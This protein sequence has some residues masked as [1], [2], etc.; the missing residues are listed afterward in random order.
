MNF[1]IKKALRKLLDKLEI[2]VATT[3]I[4]VSHEAT[5]SIYSYTYL[6]SSTY[7]YSADF[8]VVQEQ[9]Y[10]IINLDPSFISNVG[11]IS[12]IRLL[13][14]VIYLDFLEFF[15]SKLGASEG[16][17]F[18]SV[19]ADNPLNVTQATMTSVQRNIVDVL[20]DNLRD[21]KEPLAHVDA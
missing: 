2:R 1:L 12:D 6:V 4:D 11:F 21:S 8:L 9:N 3:P 14:Q 13:Q 19:L 16:F 17:S 5:K 7:P 10:R 15:D 20:S 18:L